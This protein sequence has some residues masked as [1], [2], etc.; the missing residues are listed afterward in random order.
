ML[1]P[2]LTHLARTLQQDSADIP[3][4]VRERIDFINQLT[5]RYNEAQTLEELDTIRKDAWEPGTVLHHFDR[6]SLEAIYFG[7]SRQI[8]E[9][10]ESRKKE[11]NH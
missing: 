5:Q 4:I 3:Q 2:D 10:L 8:L 9:E 7:R 11:N 6:M 1:K